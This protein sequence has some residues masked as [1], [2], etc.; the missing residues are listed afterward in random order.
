MLHDLTLGPSHT[1]PLVNFV[2][3]HSLHSRLDQLSTLFNIGAPRSYPAHTHI[4]FCPVAPSQIVPPDTDPYP[5]KICLPNSLPFRRRRPKILHPLLSSSPQ[6]PLKKG[7]KSEGVIVNPTP[8]G[9]NGRHRS[10]AFEQ[11]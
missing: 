3:L 7:G 10:R 4:D 9:L 5:K 2:A 6:M 1:L 11:D 8:F